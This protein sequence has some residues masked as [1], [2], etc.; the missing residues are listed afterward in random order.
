MS[1]KRSKLTVNDFSGGFNTEI[2]LLK[3][4][5]NIC[6]DELNML[7]Q[8]DGSRAKRLGFDLEPS[9]KIAATDLLVNPTKTVGFNTFF[10]E[11]AGGISG[12]KFLVVQVGSYLAIHDTSVTPISD[13]PIYSYT[14]TDDHYDTTFSF[15]AVDGVLVFVTGRKPVYSISYNG[16]T[17]SF[18]TQFLRI[19]DLFGVKADGIVKT[20]LPPKTYSTDHS[21]YLTLTYTT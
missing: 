21:H 6:S 11:N 13:T 4:Q 17:F 16:T 1:R 3:E 8:N 7:I 5:P 12:T 18:S 19:R 14:F 20:Y 9:Y 10:W 15:T 2:N